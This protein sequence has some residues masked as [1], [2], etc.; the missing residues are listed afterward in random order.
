MRKNGHRDVLSL[1]IA[2]PFE[3]TLQLVAFDLLRRPNNDQKTKKDK[4]KEER[5]RR[6]SKIAQ[7]V[8]L[9]LKGISYLHDK[10]SSCITS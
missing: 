7:N 8:V 9:I 5:N 3:L 10:S 2:V 6:Y 4:K 1:S